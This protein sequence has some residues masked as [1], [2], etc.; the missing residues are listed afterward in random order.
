MA[1]KADKNQDDRTI[2]KDR[3]SR[4]PIASVKMPHGWKVVNTNIDYKKSTLEIPYAISIELENRTGSK[5]IIDS[6]DSFVNQG[7]VAYYHNQVPHTMQHHFTTVDKYL[8]S[9][10]DNY[11]KNSKKTVEFKEELPI[12]LAGYNRDDDFI[13]HRTSIEQEVQKAAAASGGRV[14]I[15]GIYC[16][17]ACRAYK[18]GKNTI[19]AYTR[20]IGS[21][22]GL[23]NLGIFG[24]DGINNTVDNLGNLVKTAKDKT[25]AAA[26][27]SDGGGSIL[28]HLAQRG[29][30][31]NLLGNK[32]RSQPNRLVE[33][34]Q[35][36]TVDTDDEDVEVHEK[37]DVEVDNPVLFGRMNKPGQGEWIEWKAGPIFMLITPETDYEELFKNDLKQI[38]S[39]FKLS[40]EVN[41]EFQDLT[42]QME[43]EQ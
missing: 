4:K 25:M 7:A 24:G 1:E 38:C 32:K 30:I 11:T 39:S 3:A 16:D 17:S 23:A 15:N 5:L 9:Y 22:A 28:N 29:L 14:V 19:I 34:Q 42:T 2:I 26:K 31:S 36:P 13:K 43:E 12:P 33:T 37:Q 41:R 27:S 40:Q 21:Q 18:H 35:S 10:V 20:E 8:D 6:G